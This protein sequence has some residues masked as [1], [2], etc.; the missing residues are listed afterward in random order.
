[1]EEVGKCPEIGEL[2]ASRGW[3]LRDSDPEAD[4]S[5][6][7]LVSDLVFSPSPIH[8]LSHTTANVTDLQAIHHTRCL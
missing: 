6:S 8:R 4:M 2:V 3:R 1:M 7:P 5:S